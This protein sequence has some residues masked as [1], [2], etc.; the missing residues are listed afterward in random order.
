MDQ[1]TFTLTDFLCLDSVRKG[2][3]RMSKN[4]DFL[5]TKIKID[6]FEEKILLT[7]Y[8]VKSCTSS[9]GFK[10]EKLTKDIF[11]VIPKSLTLLKN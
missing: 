4:K 6:G 3:V 2:I 1:K 9:R 8:D 5:A 10:I 11:A 7:K